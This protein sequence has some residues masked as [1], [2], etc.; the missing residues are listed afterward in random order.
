MADIGCAA[1]PSPH[2]RVK[3]PPM[4]HLTTGTALFIAALMLG[5]LGAGCGS[6]SGGDATGP[7][8]GTWTFGPSSMLSGTCAGTPAT[9]P[10]AGQTA[11]ITKVDSST[12]NLAV[13]TNCDVKFKISGS[14]A[15]AAANQPCTLTFM[16]AA[17]NVN[18]T[19]WTLT[20]AGAM[21]NTMTSGTALGGICTAT[22]S[23]TL[24]RAGGGDGG[25]PDG[26]AAAPAD[27]A[28]GG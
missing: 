24:T 18:I 25:T 8:V 6:S 23:G 2:V 22:G 14:T 15:S 7:F 3:I 13:G 1:Y 20:T 17:Q 4:R 28:G 11:T 27:A 19:S 9:V 5:A 26:D 10:L 16:G 12:V 21:L